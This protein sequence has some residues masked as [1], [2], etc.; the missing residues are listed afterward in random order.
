MGLNKQQYDQIIRGYELTRD[1]NRYI[2]AERRKKVYAKIPPYRIL[3]ESLGGIASKRVRLAIEGDES[4]LSDLHEEIN[5]ISIKKKL[6][7]SDGGFPADFL[8]PIYDCPDCHDTGYITDPDGL[9]TKCHCFRDREIE[10]L[11][12]QTNIREALAENNFD[13]LSYDFQEGEDLVHFK[14]AV[15]VCREFVQNFEQDYHNILFYGT[16]GTGKSFLSGCIANEIILKGRSVLYFSAEKL[17]E[18]LA[19]YSF[20]HEHK[21]ELY[22]FYSD[23]YNADLLIIDD[24]ATEVS[25]AFVST[26]LFSCINERHL[27]K[28]ATIISTNLNLDELRDR[29]SDRVFSRISNN[30]KLCKL[31]GKDVRLI[32]RDLAQVI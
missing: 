28:K 25:N 12:D 11:Y 20:G 18:D 19:Y 4:A 9:K 13:A 5:K 27:R 26:Q 21:D 7:L 24:L 6:L 10:I 22:D 16:V 32:K 2:S 8:D 1:K 23:L 14:K 17:F 30:Y 31:V 29:Y 3:D 15:K